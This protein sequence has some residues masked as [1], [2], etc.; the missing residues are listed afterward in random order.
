MLPTL[1]IHTFRQKLRFWMLSWLL[2]R[3]P[4][5]AKPK[6]EGS[7]EGCA[8]YK[9]PNRSFHAVGFLHISRLLSLFVCKLALNVVT[10]DPS[11]YVV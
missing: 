7:P 5:A 1:P 8:T 2:M 4:W 11:V 3:L 10:M 9:V 6:D